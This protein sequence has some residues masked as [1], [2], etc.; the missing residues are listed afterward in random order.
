MAAVSVAVL[1]IVELGFYAYIVKP[2]YEPMLHYCVYYFNALWPV[3]K[4]K[5]Y[6]MKS[7]TQ[8]FDILAS[9]DED[10]RRNSLAARK[11]SKIV[12]SD[13]HKEEQR[14][15]A[16]LDDKK[17]ES[18]KNVALTISKLTKRYKLEEAAVENLSY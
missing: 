15:I 7:D 17:K 3:K 12:D 2:I 9:D 14:V 4:V 16:S 6:R 10:D 11:F 1:F 8:K 5:L 18:R 13:P